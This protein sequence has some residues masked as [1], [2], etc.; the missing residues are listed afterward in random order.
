M[1]I[2]LKIESA[3]H[4]ASR[5]SD[6]KAAWAV[7]QEGWDAA[8]AAA[9]G[10]EREKALKWVGGAIAAYAAMVGKDRKDVLIELERSK[11]L[12]SG[13]TVELPPEIP[14]FQPGRSTPPPPRLPGAQRSLT[15]EEIAAENRSEP[16]TSS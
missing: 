2:S 12:A 7:V 13:P 5:K 14:V 3:K 10:D 4:R 16:S 1:R 6:G 9:P 15:P 11:P 8:R